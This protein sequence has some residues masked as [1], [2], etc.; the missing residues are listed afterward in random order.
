LKTQLNTYPQFSIIG[1]SI[2]SFILIFEHFFRTELQPYTHFLSEY[3]LGPYGWIHVTAFA[4]LSVTNLLIFFNLFK[5]IR[6]S[7]VSIFTY[8]VFC[9][10]IFLVTIFP[11][12]A[13]GQADTTA[14]QLHIMA[15]NIAFLSFAIGL[16]SWAYDF[17]RQ[18]GWENTAIQTLL[19]GILGFAIFGL[20]QAG[21]TNKAG[22]IQRILLINNLAWL[23]IVSV[24]MYLLAKG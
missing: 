17:W 19:I 7:L 22:L 15:A 11:T 16:F 24:K 23:Y 18:T 1:L 6:C 10:G 9:M 4:V 8:L 20:A 3:S 21:F 12:D 2:F 14:G 13:P 5:N